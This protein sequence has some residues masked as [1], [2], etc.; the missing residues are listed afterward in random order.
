MRSE[1]VGRGGR[2]KEE[3][4]A[5]TP[6]FRLFEEG[7][8][9]GGRRGDRNPNAAPLSMRQPISTGRPD[10]A[11]EAEA[12][13]LKAETAASWGKE[14]D[15]RRAGE[16]K[17]GN[18]RSADRKGERGDRKVRPIS[19]EGEGKEGEEGG[20]GSRSEG[21]A[22]RFRMAN[23]RGGP[24]IVGEVAAA[25]EAVTGGKGGE[26]ARMGRKGGGPP[27]E[28]GAR[29]GTAAATVISANRRSAA[30]GAARQ[31][32]GGTGPLP[33]PTV[34]AIAATG[35]GKG[36]DPSSLFAACRPQRKEAFKVADGLSGEGRKGREDTV[37]PPH[38]ISERMRG[39]AATPL[40]LP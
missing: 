12:A 25:E 30:E 31:K 17:G 1:M 35:E 22:I 21:A 40:L 4:T 2:G 15:D 13:L 16:R 8:E 36:G 19:W 14:G 20:S 39:K 33:Q 29:T 3:G 28:G 7:G 27:V 18:F 32:G 23:E 24:T 9:D 6:T 38:P 11:E 34:E 10:A 5:A 37:R 26:V